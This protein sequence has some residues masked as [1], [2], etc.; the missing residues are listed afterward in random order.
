MKRQTASRLHK[1]GEETLPAAAT[2]ARA[3]SPAKNALTPPFAWLVLAMFAVSAATACA[4]DWMKDWIGGGYTGPSAMTVITVGEAKKLPDDT[5]VILE[6]HI[7]ERLGNERYLFSD[8]AD[9][10][11]LEIDDEDWRG[12]H[13]GAEDTVIL[14]GEVDRRF[15]QIKIDVDRIEKKKQ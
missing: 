2:P 9:T 1:T 14:Y 12:L 4:D 11:T 13:V 6:G 3:E 8:G 15:G 5:D 7:T 10:I